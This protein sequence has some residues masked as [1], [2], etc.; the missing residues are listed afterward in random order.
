MRGILAVAEFNTILCK[1][2]EGGMMELDRDI[3]I[4]VVVCTRLVNPNLGHVDSRIK[5][6]LNFSGLTV[7]QT[8]IATF[9]FLT[10]KKNRRV[11]ARTTAENSEKSELY[12]TKQANVL[13]DE[14][15]MC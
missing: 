5:I 12:S 14:K 2:K 10:C 7:Q 9:K 3:L 8:I 6:L 4:K 11:I 1:V 13:L 15:H